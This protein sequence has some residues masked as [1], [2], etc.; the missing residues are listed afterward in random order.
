MSANAPARDTEQ[1][2]QLALWDTTTRS[3]V[4]LQHQQTG[5]FNVVISPD[6]RCLLVIPGSGDP[7]LYDIKSRK[8]V[9][10]LRQEGTP[11]GSSAAF[12]PDGNTVLTY[13]SV[14]GVFVWQTSDGKLLGVAGQYAQDL[15]DLLNGPKVGA[16]EFVAGGRRFISYS[17]NGVVRVWNL[18]GL[19]L[20]A[21]T[22]DEDARD[23]QTVLDGRRMITTQQNGSV[24][25][26]ELPE[27]T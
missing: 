9:A 24:R 13:S 27:T 22:H 6:R 7:A 10:S 21:T 18:A 12:S 14:D 26:S 17:M 20:L 19:Q 2:Y 15:M 23:Y 11:I 8:A 25:I 4:G 5:G 1:K 3:K 16:V